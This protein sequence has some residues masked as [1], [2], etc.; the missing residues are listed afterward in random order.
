MGLE[1]VLHNQVGSLSRLPGQLELQAKLCDLVA[2]L[3]GEDIG[4]IQQLSKV[5]LYYQVV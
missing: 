1:T 2:S 3:P 4:C 5:G